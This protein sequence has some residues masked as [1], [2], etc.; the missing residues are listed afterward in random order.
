MPDGDVGRGLVRPALVR[1]GGSR[2]VFSNGKKTLQR[3]NAANNI[4]P[5]IANSEQSSGMFGVGEQSKNPLSVMTAAVDKSKHSLHRL[6]GATSLYTN[7]VDNDL[8]TATC[9]TTSTS[10]AS[11]EE[12]QVLPDL[13]STVSSLRVTNF[14]HEETIRKMKKKLSKLE[15]RMKSQ[16][17]STAAEVNSRKEKHSLVEKAL[18]REKRSS[19]RTRRGEG[20]KDPSPQSDDWADRRDQDRSNDN[21]LMEMIRRLTHENGLLL[22]KC[23]QLGEVESQ[24]DE[25]LVLVEELRVENDAI[26]RS[27]DDAMQ[28]MSG[29]RQKMAGCAREHVGCVRDYETQVASLKDE[30]DRAVLS[31]AELN[32]LWLTRLEERKEEEEKLKKENREAY[33]TCEV[34][35]REIDMLYEALEESRAGNKSNSVEDANGSD[36]DDDDNEKMAQ[37][38]KL[39][40]ISW[41]DDT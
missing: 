30:I 6:N 37:I 38:R 41:S 5:S 27:M 19:S 26:N 21:E 25:L 24:R 20:N 28:L 36:G 9:S 22:A 35:Q 29:M 18:P 12:S 40:K 15:S 23:Q 11:I 39:K 17:E 7:G 14:Q 13:V 16:S 34:L 2:F 33:Q 10:F 8:S 4:E 31:R 3:S 32:T 1:A